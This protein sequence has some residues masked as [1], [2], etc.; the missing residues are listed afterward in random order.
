MCVFVSTILVYCCVVVTVLCTSKGLYYIDVFGTRYCL[1]DAVR[2]CEGLVFM[3]GLIYLHQYFEGKTGGKAGLIGL[4]IQS[5]KGMITVG[6]V[7][8][9][10]SAKLYST[11]SYLNSVKATK[12]HAPQDT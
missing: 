4:Y 8:P 3:Q 7:P 6:C 11:T 12:S 9:A 5:P 2:P 10:K 1:C